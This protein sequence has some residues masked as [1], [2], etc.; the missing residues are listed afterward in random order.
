[1]AYKCCDCGHIFDDG[2]QRAV[3]ECHSE[4]DGT[5]YEEF[6]VCPVCG[7]GYEETIHCGICGGEFTK[8]ELYCGVCEDCLSESITYDNVLQYLLDYHLLDEFMFETWFKSSVPS[9]ISEE[10]EATL[11]EWFM[12]LRANDL[13]CGT[14]ELL[15]K[16][17]EF[18]EEDAFSKADFADWVLERKEANYG[19]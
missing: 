12:R 1:M 10:L 5:C 3:K 14:S 7:G 13:L 16:C 2:E 6:F 19:I 11:Q 17:R 8:D 9:R 4:V 18:V 15:D